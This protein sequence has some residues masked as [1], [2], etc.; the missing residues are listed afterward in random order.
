M[1]R[2][3]VGKY[4]LLVLTCWP[5]VYAAIV[6][7]FIYDELVRSLAIVVDPE[8]ASQEL[9]IIFRLHIATVVIGFC[10]FIYY[11]YRLYIDKSVSGESKMLWFVS[12]FVLTSFAYLAYWW[13]HIRPSEDFSSL[14]NT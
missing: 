5:I 2:Q 3:A 10:T 7:L 12:F 11:S 8:Q 1:N 13:K 9:H 4:L 14:V 6:G